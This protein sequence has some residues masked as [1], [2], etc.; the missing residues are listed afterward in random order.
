MDYDNLLKRTR[1]DAF[2]VSQNK[3][4]QILSATAVLPPTTKKASGIEFYRKKQSALQMEKEL[5]E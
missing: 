2:E 4:L 5:K 1:A 3:N